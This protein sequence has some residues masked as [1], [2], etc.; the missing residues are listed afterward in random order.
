MVLLSFSVE[1]S[2]SIGAY[3]FTIGQEYKFK[4]IKLIYINWIWHSDALN[5]QIDDADADME[6]PTRVHPAELGL[7]FDFLD[8][9]DCVNYS[10]KADSTET[11]TTGLFPFG[12]AQYSLPALTGDETTQHGE[13]QRNFQDTYLMKDRPT[14]WALNKD[15]SI[16]LYF[17]SVETDSAIGE[18]VV[19]DAAS[20]DDGSKYTVV[21]SLE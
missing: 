14:T 18:W 7:H 6:G 8:T 20:F 11:I 15:I 9:K 1:G 13:V 19:T 21:L 16:S 12:S 17:R 5:D 3:T 2:D 10:S 4:S